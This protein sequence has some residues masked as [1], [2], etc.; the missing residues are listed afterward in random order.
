MSPEER[1]AK[2]A[3]LKED[4]TREFT[5]GNH[6]TAAVLYKEAADFVDE[7]EGDELIGTAVSDEEAR[8]PRVPAA[9]RHR[10]RG[11][12]VWQAAPARARR[13]A[14]TRSCFA[15][16]F[17][18]QQGPTSCADLLSHVDHSLFPCCPCA[19]GGRRAS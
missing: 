19:A 5:S 12:L 9:G 3:A 18:T 1:L 13:R 14:C 6:A 17:G 2:A 16:G 11:R 7:E 10:G 15:T 4:G 8:R